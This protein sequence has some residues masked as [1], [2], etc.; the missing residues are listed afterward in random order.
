MAAVWVRGRNGDDLAAQRPHQL[1]VF[2]FRIDNDNIVVGREGQR[3][4]FLLCRH[5]LAGA[6]HA[7]NKA[8]AVEQVSSIA[9]DK[10][11][12]NSIDAVVDAASVLNFL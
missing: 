11:V 9:D 5:A 1:A 7:G 12:G 3:G 4:H 10:V 8:V 2:A 6:G